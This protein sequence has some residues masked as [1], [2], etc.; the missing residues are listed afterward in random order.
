M[1]TTPPDVQAALAAAWRAQ[2][3]PELLTNLAFADTPAADEPL[4]ECAEFFQSVMPIPPCKPRCRKADH[5]SEPSPHKP[6]WTQTTCL[7]CNA[8]VSFKRDTASLDGQHVASAVAGNATPG[9]QLAMG[10]ARDD[11][12]IHAQPLPLPRLTV[13]PGGGPQH[14]R[15]TAEARKS[16]TGGGGRDRAHHS[17]KRQELDA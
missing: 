2:P 6:G 10:F 14:T 16:V 9:R 17:N 13:P 7:R 8:F 15:G 11:S 5:V 12:E 4:A 3:K 1:S